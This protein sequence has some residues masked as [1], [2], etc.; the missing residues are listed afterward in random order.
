[1]RTMLMIWVFTSL[2]LSFSCTT[3]TTEPLPDDSSADS[4]GDVEQGLT[5]CDCPQGT[6][7]NGTGCSGYA[8][9]G[10]DSNTCVAN[11]Q[12]TSGLCTVNS[13]V[14]S[15]YG[16]CEGGALSCNCPRGTYWDGTGCS[17]YAVFGGDANTCVVSCQCPSGQCTVNNG[18]P[19]PYGHCL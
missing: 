9:F 19:F 7:W 5:S 17:G 14:P 13:G 8:V 2:F 10:P 1:M 12:C 16:H 4:V 6:Y 3:N 15:P 11:C 18:L